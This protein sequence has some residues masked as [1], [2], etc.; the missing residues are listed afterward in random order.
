[1]RI[2][3]ILPGPVRIPM[4][5]AK[6]VY[7][8]ASGL[9]ERGHQVTV[10][11]P[12]R[13]NGGLL[14]WVRE[15]A[16]R[17]R[18]RWHGV[19]TAGAYYEPIGV[20]TRVLPRVEADTIPDGEAVIATGAQT[21][22]WVQALPD[23]KG[24]RFYFIQGYETFVDARALD[25]WHLPLHR[26]TCSSWLAREVEKAGEGVIG[27][28]PNAID[29]SEFNLQRPIEGRAPRIV[30]LYHRHEVKGP[31]VLIDALRTIGKA[32]P[33]V[34][35]DIITARPPSHSLPSWVHLH[36]RPSLDEL[37]RIYNA[38][39][40]VL[41]TSRSEGWAL[42][43]MEAAACGCAVAA[44]LNFGIQEYLEDGR[45]MRGVAVGDGVELGLATL[46]LLEDDEVRV[47]LAHAAHEAVSAFTWKASTDHLESLLLQTTT[48]TDAS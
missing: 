43:P 28:V 3:F 38:A 46:D 47:N 5:G 48:R 1:M 17:V 25:T 10:V 45:S 40:I 19:G 15:Q 20:T 6:V 42:V 37:R 8:H 27:V 26:F 7:A 12:T 2:T 16:V 13:A 11:T 29:P 33:E 32:R 14:G 24:D 30:A 23:S 9:A 34:A 18:D 41:H 22:P 31:D 44:S 4:G 36:I 39:S 35:V 21:A